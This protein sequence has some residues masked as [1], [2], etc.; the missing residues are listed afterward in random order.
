MRIGDL[1][2]PDGI[3]L[4]AVRRDG[5]VLRAHDGLVLH[6]DDQLT[7]IGPSGGL[8]SLLDLTTALT[9]EP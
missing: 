9:G 3:D 6:A 4:E 7:I 5:S 2:P 8:P 1:S